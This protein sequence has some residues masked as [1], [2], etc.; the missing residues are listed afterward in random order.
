M[1]TLYHYTTKSNLDSIL[2]TNKI[3][4]SDPL[5]TMDAAY[6]V[7]YY[8]TDLGI[9][10]CDIAIAFRCW[11][12]IKALGKIECYIKFEVEDDVLTKCRDNVYLITNWDIAK[13]KFIEGK[14]IP[15]CS[16]YPCETC[17]TGKKIIKKFSKN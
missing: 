10:K 3:K 1:K 5:T 2:A 17:E 16:K 6:G 13:V 12:S 4:A 15:S 8:M 7:G 11:K 9:D 14:E